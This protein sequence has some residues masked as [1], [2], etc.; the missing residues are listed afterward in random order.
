M[1]APLVKSLLLAGILSLPT[2]S[3]A[4]EKLPPAPIHSGW[5]E[6]VLSVTDIQR[7]LSFFTDIAGWELLEQGE[8]DPQLIKLWELPETASARF[9]IVRNPGSTRGYIRLLQFSG[10]EQKIIRSNTQSWD[11]GGIFDLNVRVNNMEKKFSQMSALGW[12][13][14]SDPVQFSFGPYVVKEWIV[15]G[16]DGL[17]FALIE[18]VK[19]NLEGWPHLKEF[20]RTFNST[21]IVR[22]MA[23]ALDFYT[24]V[25]GF[26]TYLEHRGTSKKPGPN[27]LGLPHN[28]STDIPREVYILHPKGHNEGSVE[29]LSFDGATGRDLAE[30]AT[31]PNIGLLMLRFPV[32]DT[33]ALAAH[34][35]R[36]NTP[37]VSSVISANLPPYGQAK[38]LATR[39]PD[40]TWLEFYQ[41]K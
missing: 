34:L 3:S 28:L 6:A 4:N 1:I 18:R 21:Q 20:S 33:A 31:P 32:T 27:V 9:A 19:P 12:Q 36:H 41:T 16:P 26:K 30:R 35:K 7:H 5:T 22:A 10:V 38:L 25:L 29:L 37:W 2:A 40:G 23:P 17:T 13:A 14:T 11:S 15:R 24:N 8:V 39:A